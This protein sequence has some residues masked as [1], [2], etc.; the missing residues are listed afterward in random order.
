MKMNERRTWICSLAH[1]LIGVPYIWG[2][3][4]P[5][6]G[7]DCSGFAIWILQVFEILPAMDDTAEGLSRRF[8]HRGPG[9]ALE[10]GDLVFYGG[11]FE[12]ITHVMIYA[13]QLDGTDYVVGASGGD[14]TTTTEEAANKRGAMV[15][16]KPMHYRRDYVCAGNID[17]QRQV[18]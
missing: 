9:E 5:H 12:S 6:V 18:M 2:G 11:G 13:G 15:K 8:P 1:K 3:S 16:M 10:K 4:N 14:H 7:F 17:G